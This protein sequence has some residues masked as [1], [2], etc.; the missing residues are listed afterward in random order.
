MKIVVY[1]KTKNRI[2]ALIKRWKRLYDEHTERDCCFFANKESSFL[3]GIKRDKI[4]AT[5]WWIKKNEKNKKQKKKTTKTPKHK[6]KT[7]KEN[8]NTKTQKQN[9]HEKPQNKNSLNPPWREKIKRWKILLFELFGIDKL[10]Q[11]L[12]TIC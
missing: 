9:K 10:C 2:G 3:C 1:Y 7:K 8:Q 5:I 11:R 12:E 4:L 6:Q